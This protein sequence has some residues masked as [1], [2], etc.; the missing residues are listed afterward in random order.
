MNSPRVLI[1]GVFLESHSFAPLP[2]GEGSFVVTEGDGLLG[3]LG[4]SESVLGGGARELLQRGATLIPT[5]SAVAPPGGLADHQLYLSFRERLVEAARTHRPDAI[6][7]ELHGA[8]GTTAIDDSE[9]DLAS[10]L[11]EAVGPE[12]PIAAGLDMH[13]C[14]THRML[15]ATPLWVACKENPHTDYAETGARAAGLLM[16]T[17]GGDIDPVTVAVWLPLLLRG[18]LGTGTGPLAEL[19]ALRRALETEGGLEDISIY[20]AYAFLDCAEAGQCV[21][22]T[23]DG[24]RP[25]ALDAARRLAETLWARRHDFG[26]DRPS[27]EAVLEAHAPGQGTVVI[28]DHG[29]RVLGGSA[30]DGT[31]LLHLLR[32]RTD[33][34]ALVPVT[35]PAAAARA[36]AVGEGGVIDCDVGGG[37]TAGEAPYPGRW[38]VK[39]I[40]EGRFVQQGPFL[41][42]EPADMGRCAVLQDGA[43]VVLATS[44]PAMS[45]DPACFLSVGEDP[46]GFDVVVCKSGF[47]FEPA[48]ARY[49]RV[50]AVDTPGITNYVPGRFDFRRRPTYW[51]EDPSIE[52]DFAAQ[53]FP[54]PGARRGGGE[55]VA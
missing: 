14:V 18:R 37:F 7:L 51:P 4:N 36:A 24:R 6:F 9:G 22:A 52:P 49:G 21:T 33:L 10:A 42:N 54:Q 29:D 44:K 50:V 11:R 53:A 3:K 43:L 41:A 28:G 25:E 34:R 45:Q 26:V 20:N 27:A 23:S 48:F 38:T 12:I 17:L 47:H 1:G 46:A 40:A 32:D 8:M 19:H 16:R 13:A 55:R 39:R 2:S 5:F 30:G 31:Y 15:E 35:D